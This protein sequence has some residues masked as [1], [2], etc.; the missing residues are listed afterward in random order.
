MWT[1]RLFPETAGEAAISVFSDL[2]QATLPV[3]IEIGPK[4]VA[5]NQAALKQRV[6][7]GPKAFVP[8]PDLRTRLDEMLAALQQELLERARR[9]RDENSVRLDSYADFKALMEPVTAERGGGKFVYAHW[10]G[11]GDCEGEIK[12]RTGGAS[13]RVKPFN[14][15]AESGQCILCRQPSEGR[16]LFAKAY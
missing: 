6:G 7:E 12:Y 11:S 8:L 1:T 14:V 4:D 10:C 16:V 2:L 13:I 5:A 9:L 3:R 15:P